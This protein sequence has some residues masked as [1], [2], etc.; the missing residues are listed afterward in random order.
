[1]RRVAVTAP[2]EARVVAGALLLATQLQRLAA[3]V[4]AIPV[5]AA[6][7][8]ARILR[9]RL[10]SSAGP[11]WSPS[12]ASAALAA[13]ALRTAAVPQHLGGRSRPGLDRRLAL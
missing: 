3:I 1:M 2:L 5:Y 4:V 8:L 7:V 10:A 9:S 13:A 6:S 11:R 12:A